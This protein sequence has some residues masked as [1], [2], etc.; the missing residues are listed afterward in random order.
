MVFN[1]A[2]SSAEMVCQ[3]SASVYTL[4]ERAPVP[5]LIKPRTVSCAI[6]RQAVRVDALSQTKP[7]QFN[8]IALTFFNEVAGP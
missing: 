8:R 7:E 4:A 5:T 2:A 6:A 1:R 3:P